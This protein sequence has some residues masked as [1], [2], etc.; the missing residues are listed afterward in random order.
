MKH[1]ISISLNGS[2]QETLVHQAKG[3]LGLRIFDSLH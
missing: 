1:Q 3:M 2:N